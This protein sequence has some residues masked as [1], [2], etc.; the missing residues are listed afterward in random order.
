MKARAILVGL[1]PRVRGNRLL[2]QSRNVAI[3]SIP[4]CA[5]EPG[6]RVVVIPGVRVYPRV[7]GGTWSNPNRESKAGGLSPRVRG[8]HM[9]PD[10]VRNVVGSIPACAGEPVIGTNAPGWSRVYPRVC[11]GTPTIRKHDSE[12][13][14]LSPRV[15]GNQVTVSGAAVGAG[16]IPACAGEPLQTARALPRS[17]VYPRVCGGT[18]SLTV[19]ESCGWGL[20][21]R[22]RGN[23]FL[24]WGVVRLS[25]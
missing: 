6:R 9:N 23:P 4:A 12:F 2:Y 17:E 20:S 5:G 19:T 3:R 1:S 22:V 18:Q 8:N 13:W 21:P 11:G 14:G 25:A 15:R 24:T 10:S 7:C 16:S